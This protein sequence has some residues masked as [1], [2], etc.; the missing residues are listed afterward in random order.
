MRFKEEGD[1][2]ISL[3]LADRDE[4][5]ETPVE[6]PEAPNDEGTTPENQ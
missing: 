6:A 1:R 2:V 4:T 5:A 3:A